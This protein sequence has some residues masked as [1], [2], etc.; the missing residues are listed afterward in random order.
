MR[1]Q[2]KIVASGPNFV[3]NEKESINHV[4][5]LNFIAWSIT[6]KFQDTQFIN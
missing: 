5:W 6:V 3:F 2:T 4:Q 1:G